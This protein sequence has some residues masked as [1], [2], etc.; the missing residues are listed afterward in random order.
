MLFSKLVVRGK[1]NRSLRAV[2]ADEFLRAANVDQ[3]AV[4][5][6]RDAIAETLSLLHQMSGHE[7]GLATF[8]DITHQI[9]NGPPGLRVEPRG[10]FIEKH[11]LRIV[12]QRQGDEQPLLLASRERHEPGVPLVGKTELFQQ[13][14]AVDCHGVEG[15]PEVKRLPYLDP[16]LELRLLELHSNTTLQRINIAK[17]IDP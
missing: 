15:G 11:D 10:E 1:H 4:L 13:A 14:I 2:S 7:D 16:L 3:A 8:A 9:P 6:N 17:G 5:D 12:D